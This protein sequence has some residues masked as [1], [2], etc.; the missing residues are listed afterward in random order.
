MLCQENLL[1]LVCFDLPLYRIPCGRKALRG[2]DGAG[3]VA[4]EVAGPF[5]LFHRDNAYRFAKSFIHKLPGHFTENTP[6]QLTCDPVETHARWWCAPAASLVSP[7]RR[8]G[9]SRG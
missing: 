4:R 5:H 6:M 2:V 3:A 1:Q 8:P 9:P 7:M